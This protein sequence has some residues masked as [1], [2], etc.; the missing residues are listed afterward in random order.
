MLFPLRFCLFKDCAEI[1]AYCYL[2][3][4]QLSYFLQNVA[5]NERK[6]HC[7]G[8]GKKC[9]KSIFSFVQH[10]PAKS[11]P[12]TLLQSR[13]SLYLTEPAHVGVY[14]EEEMTSRIILL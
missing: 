13:D 6:S 11:L 2:T 5:E 14:K 1:E 10:F 8:I 9:A 3:F 4:N 7:V 12:G